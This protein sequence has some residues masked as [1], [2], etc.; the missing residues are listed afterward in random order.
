MVYPDQL[1]MDNFRILFG[2][3]L[4]SQ[5]IGATKTM[6]AKMAIHSV[7][8]TPLRGMIFTVHTERRGFF[9][10]WISQEDI[11][12]L[13]EWDPAE[14]ALAVIVDQDDSK[15]IIIRPLHKEPDVKYTLYPTP[16]TVAKEK[17][18]E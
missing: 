6:S 18:D 12:A 8:G 13:N 2:H 15:N 10:Y 11:A 4:F 1:E 16:F 9:E 14:I 3:A 7:L 17:D 5:G